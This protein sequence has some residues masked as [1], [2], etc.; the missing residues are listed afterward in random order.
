M[1]SA[2]LKPAHVLFAVIVLAVL[3]ITGWFLTR[4]VELPVE[5]ATGMKV[6]DKLRRV[7][8]VQR[9]G[10]VDASPYAE[11]I[12]AVEALIYGD[13]PIR[14]EREAVL[15][16]AV[17][18]L[19]DA[20][21]ETAS[22]NHHF[23]SIRIRSLV[24]RFPKLRGADGSL[25]QVD[26]AATW[27]AARR[28]VFRPGSWEQRAATPAAATPAPTPAAVEAVSWTEAD[29]ALLPNLS[30]WLADLEA[31][32][33]AGLSGA[34]AIGDT[35]PEADWAA[36]VEPFKG[37]LLRSDTE[38]ATEPADRDSTAHA[39][40][41]SLSTARAALYAMSGEGRIPAW[42]QRKQRQQEAAEAL[43]RARALVDQ[44]RRSP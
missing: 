26:L 16:K 7:R 28:D 25:D 10:T 33:Q 18:T 8:A 35:R 43:T 2:K 15:R 12:Q 38:R 23:G 36:W 41:E 44:S 21:G 22:P 3:T 4:G 11:E 17:L 34:V 9:V 6:S 39:V 32:S 30:T 5:K 42:G 37:A 19:G 20:L 31:L 29:R 14:A 24:T 27:F 13:E 40:W 1:S